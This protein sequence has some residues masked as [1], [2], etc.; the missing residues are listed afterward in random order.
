MLWHT[1][2][3]GRRPWVVSQG[4]HLLT[5]ALTSPQQSR[6]VT[7]LEVTSTLWAEPWHGQPSCCGKGGLGPSLLLYPLC[8]GAGVWKCQGRAACW[9]WP[10]HSQQ[11]GH[12]GTAAVRGGAPL[13]TAPHPPAP[14]FLN[15][16]L[17][18]WVSKGMTGSRLSP[19]PL[20]TGTDLAATA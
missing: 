9:C 7:R 3:Q 11:G 20:G 12:R 2:P 1:V 19:S 4:G 6:A 17:H 14:Q 10:W 15:R 18:T 13:P 5:W 16:S 8:P